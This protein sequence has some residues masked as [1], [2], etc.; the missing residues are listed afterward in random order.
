MMWRSHALPSNF[1]KCASSRL[2]AQ[3]RRMDLLVAW[4]EGML[5]ASW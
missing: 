1:K 2:L 4:D 3:L 5:G